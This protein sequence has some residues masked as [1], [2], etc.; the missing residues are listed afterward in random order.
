MLFQVLCGFEPIFYTTHPN[1]EPEN[2]IKAI[3]ANDWRSIMS[4]KFSRFACGIP[5]ILLKNCEKL[6]TVIKA[7]IPLN[8]IWILSEKV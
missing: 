8:Q 2:R 7:E 3:E 5:R 6:K 4:I 1:E